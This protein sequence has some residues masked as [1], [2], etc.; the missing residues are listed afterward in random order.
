M[1]ARLKSLGLTALLWAFGL[2]AMPAVAQVTPAAGPA[3]GAAVQARPSREQLNP[4]E[5][6]PSPSTRPR[7]S[8]DLL[9]PP[10]AGPCPLAS[11][12]LKFTLTSVEFTG[13]FKV[14]QQDLKASY[15]RD[16]GR[17]VDLSQ[18][19]RIRDRANIL[20]FRKRILA[21]V[22]VPPQRIEGGRLQLTVLEAHVVSVQVHGD[23]GPAQEQI[24]VFLDKLRGMRPFDIRKAQRYLLLASDVPGVRVSAA[25]RPA[26]QGSGA[27]DLIVFVSRKPIDAVANLQNFGSY[28]L[29][30]GGG[31]A[32]VDFNG[33]TRFGERTSLVVYS[34]LDNPE[35]RVYEILSEARIGGEGLTA[36]GSASYG[37]SAPG[38]DLAPLQLRGRSLVLDGGLTYPLIRTRTRNLNLGV[39]FDLV[40]QTTDFAQGGLLSEDHLRV[41]FLHGDG[42]QRWQSGGALLPAG[43][44]GGEVDVRRGVDGLGSS[45]PGEANLSRIGGRPD[46]LVVRGR[47]YL[48][49]AVTHSLSA[50]AVLSGQYSP[51]PLLAYE[52]FAVG[53][54]T[55][56][57]GYDPS[58][59]TG[60]RGAAGSFELHAGPFGPPTAW[61]WPANL[62]V[63]AFTFYD[64]AAIF[65][66]ETGGT[67]RTVHS[68]GVGLDLQLTSRAKLDVTYAYPFDKT[69]DFS[70]APPAPRLL[71]SLTTTFI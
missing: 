69:S 50:R 34:T 67:D 28:A 8:E 14:R 11:S 39:G 27:V 23:A 30:P 7:A 61:K 59:L 24:E 71:L 56:G 25:L 1:T 37:I 40:D 47:A 32:R 41:F 17:E 26:A 62:N 21:R 55:V 10:P 65:S 53:N 5:S 43:A 22:E 66:R 44:L 15:A 2:Q 20:L 51:T 9:A 63:S 3:A 4:A 16:I 35:Q 60:D 49:L 38:G 6:A 54:L 64:V 36:H 29:G 33:F 57:R 13:A 42:E 46:G 52:Q 19:C 48:N 18:V 45:T 70:P 68:A 58:S 31:V 12:S